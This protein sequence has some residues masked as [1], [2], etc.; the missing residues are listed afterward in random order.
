MEA[1]LQAGRSGRSMGPS[2][3]RRKK[4]AWEG[5]RPTFGRSQYG[6]RSQLGRRRRAEAA[7]LMSGADVRRARPPGGEPG[8]RSAGGK[9]RRGRGPG[10]RIGWRAA[11]ELSA[12]APPRAARRIHVVPPQ[13]APRRGLSTWTRRGISV[14]AC[15]PLVFLFPAWV[16]PRRSGSGRAL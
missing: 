16:F 14:P 8:L 2:A 9:G 4:P 11:H 13:P 5:A 7:S 6:A 10:V 1:F 3:S 12:P 15:R